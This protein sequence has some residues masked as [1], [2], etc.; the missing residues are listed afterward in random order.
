MYG[1]VTGFTLFE[2]IFD[3]IKALPAFIK[4]AIHFE[5]LEPVL[6]KVF[7]LYEYG[8]GWLLPAFVG[9]VVGLIVMFVTDA[10]KAKA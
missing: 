9:L 10:K 6:N 5:S 7:P 1:F 8:V 2:A 4:T 3:F